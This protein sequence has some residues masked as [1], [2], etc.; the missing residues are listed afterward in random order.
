M[1]L[2]RMTI[3]E[4]LESESGELVENVIILPPIVGYIPDILIQHKD[5]ITDDDLK[6]PVGGFYYDDLTAV[7]IVASEDYVEIDVEGERFERMAQEA[8]ENERLWNER[9]NLEDDGK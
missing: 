6:K 9:N 7:I 4:F 5:E 1:R 3:G 2:P 8:R